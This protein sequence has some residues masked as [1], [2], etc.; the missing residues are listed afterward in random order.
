MYT[1]TNTLDNRAKQK[2]TKITPILEDICHRL[3][4]RKKVRESVCFKV[5]DVRLRVYGKCYYTLV[6]K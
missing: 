2:V 6:L 5:G 4:H 1:F 3:L